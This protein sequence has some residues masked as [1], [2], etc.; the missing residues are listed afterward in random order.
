MIV[1]GDGIQPNL[2]QTDPHSPVGVVLGFGC[3]AF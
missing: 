1:Y 2:N 3:F